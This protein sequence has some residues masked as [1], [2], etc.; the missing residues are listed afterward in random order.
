MGREQAEIAIA[1]VSAKPAWY[2]T[3]T[4]GPVPGRDATDWHRHR[5]SGRAG[6]LW[7]HAQAYRGRDRLEAASTIRGTGPSGQMPC[8]ASAP[9]IRPIRAGS[10]FI[11][12]PMGAAPL[13]EFARNSPKIGVCGRTL[14][15]ACQ[16]Q[17]GVSPHQYVTL[18][19]MLAV[20]HALQKADPGIACV[21]DIATEHGFFELG[22]FAVKYRQTFGE[23]PSATLR[24]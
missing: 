9:R 11:L 2:F 3:T 14:R 21:T 19:R 6:S 8:F 12:A 22:R 17:L 16:E 10:S 13:V 18:W 1:I 7:S 5:F 15:A 24:A 20:R 23:L 4:P